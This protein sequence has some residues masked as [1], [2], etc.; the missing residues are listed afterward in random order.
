MHRL[1]VG[2]ESLE[3]FCALPYY[4]DCFF[5]VN[6]V[7]YTI[8]SKSYEIMFFL[9]TEG[10]DLGCRDQDLGVAAKLN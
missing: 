1:C 7:E 2:I 5:I 3:V 8:A 4:I 10:F 6:A 9:N